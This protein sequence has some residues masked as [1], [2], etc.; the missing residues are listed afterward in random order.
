MQIG[1]SLPAGTFMP[2]YTRTEK[3][4]SGLDNLL[5]GARVAQEIGYDYIEASMGAVLALSEDELTRLAGMVRAGSIR[6]HACN[7]FVPPSIPICTSSEQKLEQFVCTSM[8]AL[9]ALD[10]RT[11]IFGSG[12]ARRIP[13][14]MA[15]E[16]GMECIRSFLALCAREGEKHGVTTAIEPLN[17]TETNCVHTVRDGALLAD[18]LST[19]AI[20]LLPDLFHMAM[21]QEDPHVL[22]QYRDRIVHLHASE[23]PGRVF[24]GKYGGDY[25]RR[26]ARTLHDAQWDG[27]VTVEC[28]F[29]ERFADEAAQAYS[30]MKEVFLWNLK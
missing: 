8:R 21:E 2:E 9:D 22:M 12:A 6:L 29:G 23:A 13:D 15:H 4:I 28:V 5:Y 20:R 30:F 11:V 18:S 26:C 1:C 14:T 7:S 19:P 17:R 25:L 3:D 10:V 16:D 27:A 24:P